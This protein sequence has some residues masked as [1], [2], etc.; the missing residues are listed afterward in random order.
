MLA[1]QLAMQSDWVTADGIEAMEFP[2]LADRYA[3]NGVPHTDINDGAGSMI[4][5]APE[6][7]LVG[8]IRAALNMQPPTNESSFLGEENLTHGSENH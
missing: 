4:G 5:A 1:H 2:E 8:E 3:V 7:Y 6:D